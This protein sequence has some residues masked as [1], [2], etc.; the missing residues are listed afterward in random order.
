MRK[1]PQL[2]VLNRFWMVLNGFEYHV[3]HFVS[4]CHIL[5]MV[6]LET[7]PSGSR[8][9]P[10][11]M[12]PGWNRHG[13]K[14]CSGNLGERTKPLG[15]FYW[16]K[17]MW[18]G[19]WIIKLQLSRQV[20]FDCAQIVD[21]FDS[22]KSVFCSPTRKEWISE[23]YSALFFQP[24]TGFIMCIHIII[25]ICIKWANALVPPTPEDWIQTAQPTE[26]REKDRYANAKPPFNDT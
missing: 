15:C 23:R 24:M 2:M 17:Q 8:G 4:C 1:P 11:T 3:H 26:R 12:A 9:L 16:L 18:L 21:P 22:L 19:T 25:C 14:K 13:E 6:S 20:K 7:K 5:S 10:P